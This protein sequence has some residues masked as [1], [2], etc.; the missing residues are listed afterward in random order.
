MKIPRRGRRALA[1]A[2]ILLAGFAWGILTQRE[3][4]FPHSI[5]RSLAIRAGVRV[6][7]DTMELHSRSQAWAT[8]FGI[9]YLDGQ[10]DSRPSERGVLVDRKDRV[11][12]GVNLYSVPGLRSA[13]LVDLQGRLLWR[14][15]LSG[16]ADF[17]EIGPDIDIGFPHL[18]ANGDVIAYVKDRALMRLDRSSKIL[19]RVDGPFHHDA[20]VFDDGRI[21][22]LTHT[23]RLDPMIHPTAPVLGDNLVVYS[24]DGRKVGGFSLL[25]VIEK[26]PYAY[27][28]PK[29]DPSKPYDIFALDV[30]HANHVEVYDGRMAA[31]SPL[32][33]RG[34]IL[35]SLKDLNAIA[36]LD[37]TTHRILWLWGPS[38]LTLQHH[39]TI[40]DNGDILIFDNGAGRSRVVEVDPRSNRIVWLYDPGASFYSSIRG[41]CQRLRNGDT[42][43]GISQAGRAREVTPEGETVWD[44]A[45]PSVDG[46]VRLTIYRMTRYDR[47]AVP[48]LGTSAT[49]AN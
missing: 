27:L 25:D 45:N 4:I 41:S 7:S 2:A 11:E 21:F 36:I 28:L 16:M 19:W 8:L 37:G 42:L 34:N 44:F 10:R 32:F 17:H 33:R 47:S 12:P 1:S 6:W 31:L 5:L 48:F 43:I 3:K 35:V 29:P 39:P 14:W 30:L 40:L 23:Q 13:Y 24:P 18:F 15:T 9:P 22:A 26:S 38:N 46:G 49:A 20:F